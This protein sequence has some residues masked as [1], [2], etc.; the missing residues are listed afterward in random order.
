MQFAIGIDVG[1]TFTDVVVLKTGSDEVLTAFKLPSTRDDPGDAVIEALHRL[2]NEIDL[3]DAYV[4]HGTTV[5]TNTLIEHKGAKTA[6]ITTTGFADVIE[7]RRQDRPE[8]YQWAVKVSEPLVPRHLRFEIN[9]R[10]TYQGQVLTPLPD[11]DPLL[12]S[13]KS[14]A[15]EAVA[16]SCLHAYANSAH[17]QALR[18]EIQTAMPDCFIT[19]SHE[20]CP[21]LGEYER[22]STTVVNAYIGPPVSNYL[23]RLETEAAKL[24]VTTVMIVKSNGGLTSPEN[25][26]HFPAHLIESGPAAGIIAASTFARVSGNNDLIA[27]DMG[28]TTAK[29][30][31]VQGGAPRVTQEFLA[32][33]LID[34]RD[35]G[36]HVI[37]STVLDVVEIGAGGGSIASIDAGGVLKVGPRSAGAEP[38]P[39]CYS[40]GGTKPTVTDAHAVIGTLAAETFEGSGITFNRDLA[41]EVIEKHI[42]GPM[43]WTLARAAYAILDIAT[44]HM[45]EMVRMATVRRGL[46]PRDFALLASGGAGPLHA[47]AVATE[48]G[49]R[50]VIVPPIPGMF[51]ALGATMGEIRHDLTQSA[52]QHLKNADPAALEKGFVTLEAKANQLFSRE[53]L[54]S[55]DRSFERNADI[56][57]AGQL[58]ELRIPLSNKGLNVPSVDEIERRFRAAY[59]EEFG[60]DLPDSEVQ[61]V[62]LHLAAIMRIKGVSRWIET[63]GSE[64][65]KVPEPVRYQ[66]FLDRDGAERQMAVHRTGMATG[67]IKGP[68]LVEH[69]GS[70]IWVEGEQTACLA[71]DGS[72]T[73]EV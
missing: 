36:G 51:S 60:F 6:L 70:T 73:V 58:F 72:V 43:G 52:L 71:P 13:L 12:T 62:K 42:A 49:A 3:T 18:D 33:R 10:M 48:T 40:R 34:G 26:A 7:L 14:A 53:L 24:G 59:E 55:D 35:V 45:A 57:F 31:V 1:G 32:D 69:S 25:A 23:R 44:A 9:E 19:C 8:L 37:R 41:V 16:I 15:P 30:S 4:C 2:K 11:L 29:A 61:I 65:M 17:E 39:A 27:F 68:L 67:N 50:S 38:G 47:S 46:D 63:L 28:G 22:T 66:V 54:A 21:E 56:R 20:V 64:M 5:G